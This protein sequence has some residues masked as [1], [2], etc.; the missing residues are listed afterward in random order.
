MTQVGPKMFSVKVASD[1]SHWKF[2]RFGG[3]VMDE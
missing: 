2:D 3:L 1:Q